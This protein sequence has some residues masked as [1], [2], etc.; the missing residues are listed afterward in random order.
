MLLILRLLA[1]IALANAGLTNGD[2]M[3]IRM[4]LYRNIILYVFIY[5]F[6]NF[7]INAALPTVSVVGAY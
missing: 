7:R 5:I 3:Y 6:E 4:H 2:Y 1:L